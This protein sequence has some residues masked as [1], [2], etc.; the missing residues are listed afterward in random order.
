VSEGNV[1]KFPKLSFYQI[2][3]FGQVLRSKLIKKWVL[4]GQEDI[5][6]N[7]EL[8]RQHDHLKQIIDTVLGRNLVPS[9]P[10]FLLIIL[11]RCEDEFPHDI[12]SSAYGYYYEYLIIQALSRIKK[13][14]E[15]IDA[16]YNYITELANLL[17]E[18]KQRGLTRDN[19]LVFHKWYCE[20][21]KISPDFDET[22]TNL[23]KSHIL[24]V[25]LDCYGFRYPY[26]YYFFV[27]KYL[28]NNMTVPNIRDRVRKMCERLYQQ[29]FSNVIIFLTHLSKDPFILEQVLNSA[30]DIFTNEEPQ[31]FDNAI[32]EIN[33]LLEEIPKII[34]DTRDVDK[35]R[36][37]VLQA[38]DE[39]NPPSVEEMESLPQCDY[40]IDSQIKDPESI[41]H[42]IMSFIT[43]QVLGQILRNY[44]GSLKGNIKIALGEEAYLIGLRATNR[45]YKK[46]IASKDYLV[47]RISNIL[48]EEHIVAKDRAER[49]SRHIIFFFCTIIPKI[50]IG[51]ISQSLSYDKLIDTFDDI[52]RKHNNIGFGI[53]DL[54][55]RMD[56]HR[57]FPL[58]E[59]SSLLKR[60]G[61][62]ILPSTILKDLVVQHLYLFPRSMRERQSI[63]DKLGISRGVQ[64]QISLAQKPR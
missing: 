9:Y 31:L 26:L 4:L 34:L 44:Y 43:I 14:N 18:N 54:A 48:I 37:K 60:M 27:A 62:N 11:Q 46:L 32:V 7:Q 24:T 52:I 1:F 57:A 12:K 45:F 53:I 22:V 55:I 19:L 29:E 3:P 50:Y 51:Q 5:I 59:A 36:E 39:I 41:E 17:F 58:N 38:E 35:E 42:F 20:E 2:L 10:I 49:I 47:K 15:D 61:H 25:Y 6:S 16:Y 40:D 21:Y 30:R 8:T 33:N 56:C 64:K 23:L 63:C 28:A 13:R